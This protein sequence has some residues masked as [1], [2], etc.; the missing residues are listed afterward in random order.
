[1]NFEDPNIHGMAWHVEISLH[2][3][4]QAEMTST[5]VDSD[6]HL[7]QTLEQLQRDLVKP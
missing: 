6:E 3:E 5:E 4:A 7:T 1:M 2:R